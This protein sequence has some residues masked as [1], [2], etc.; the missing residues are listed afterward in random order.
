MTFLF[1]TSGIIASAV[2]GSLMYLQATRTKK[3]V[4]V[5]ARARRRR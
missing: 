3:P 4:R 1:L 5:L 2:L